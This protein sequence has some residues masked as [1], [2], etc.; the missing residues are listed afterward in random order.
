MKKKSFKFMMIF[1]LTLGI[2][3]AGVTISLGAYPTRPITIIVPWGAG[4][5]GT[6]NAQN[7]QPYVEKYMKQGVQVINKPGGGGTVGWNMLASS[8]ADGYTVGI[9]NPS[10][11]VTRYTTETYVDYKKLDPFILTLKIPA[12]VVVRYDAPWKTLQ[13][14]LDYAKANPGKVQMANSGYAAMYHLGIIGIEMATGVKFTHV[15]FKGSAPCITQ[16]LGG[17][18]DGSLFEIATGLQYVEAKQLRFLAI[19]SSERNPAIPDVPTFKEYGFDVDCGT[20]YG[21][22]VPQ[23]TPKDRTKMLHEAFKT[24]VNDEKFRAFYDK[25]GGVFEYKGPSEMAEFLE[26][27]NNLWKKIVDFGDFKKIK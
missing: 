6:I 10:L 4:G 19:S 17:H 9:I 22:A 13:E 24:G 16:L 14:F 20:W 25:V 15:P 3:F 12:A 23:G 5:G 18:V 21:Y 27:Q 1:I 26:E 11:L 2:L 7:L 8:A